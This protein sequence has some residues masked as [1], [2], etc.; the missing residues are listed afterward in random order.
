MFLLNAAM[1]FGLEINYT[2]DIH[3]QDMNNTEYIMS[4]DYSKSC[5]NS[6][7]YTMP[8]FDIPPDFSITGYEIRYDEGRSYELYFYSTAGKFTQDAEDLIMIEVT[9]VLPE[10]KTPDVVCTEARCDNEC[11]ICKDSRCHNPG[12]QCLE[13]IDVE[14]IFPASTKTGI[15]QMNILIRNTG[16]VDLGEIYAELSGDGI[17]TTK[18]IPIAGLVAGDKD[19]AFAEINATKPG[20]I[21]VVVKLYVNGVL[22]QKGVGQ[23]TIM[24]EEKPAEEAN[25]TGLTAL[26]DQLKDRYF[27]LE[28]EYQNKSLANY[29]LG[30]RS[31]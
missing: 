22:K 17:T 18:R 12:F 27:S 31:E 21:D 19:Y 25:V 30:T 9:E 3:L 14:K 28:Q 23:I 29:Q 13:K 8:S 15:T 2:I 4:K 6:C 1:A 5:H 10:N 26:Q 24:A 16:T 20:N 11:V 7:N